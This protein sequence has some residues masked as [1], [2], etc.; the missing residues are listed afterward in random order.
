MMTPI[1]F[2]CSVLLESMKDFIPYVVKQLLVHCV[3]TK[4]NNNVAFIEYYGYIINVQSLEDLAKN[5]MKTQY[6]ETKFCCESGVWLLCD[7]SGCSPDFQV[8]SSWFHSLCFR[9]G[10][11]YN[12]PSVTLRVSL[13]SKTVSLLLATGIQ[14]KLQAREILMTFQLSAARLQVQVFRNHKI[15]L[16]TWAVFWQGV[17]LSQLHFG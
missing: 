2:Y 4:Q 15:W 11:R 10:F 16:N 5:V 13:K 9:S 6:C 8:V 7:G 14:L 17:F 3:L 12:I 1:S